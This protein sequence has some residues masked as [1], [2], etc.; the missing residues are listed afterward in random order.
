MHRRLIGTIA[1][2]AVGAGFG[3]VTLSANAQSAPSPLIGDR[4]LA[5]RPT[6]M[7]LGSVHLGNPARDMHD[8][9]V[10]DVLAPER[11]RQI[12]RVVDAIA[13]W[14]PT[15]IAV[16]W[17]HKNQAK[18]DKRYDD[19]LAGRYALTADETDQLALRLAKKLGLKHVD[20]VDWNEDAPGPDTDYDWEAGAKL[21]HEEARFAALRDPKIDREQTALVRDHTVAGF[22]RIENAPKS[23][24]NSNRVYYD[25][26][27]LGNSEVNPGANW[28]GY[29]HARNLKIL[30]N[31]IR[32]DARPSDRVLLVIG[33]GH[34][35]LLNEYAADSHAFRVVRP[36]AWLARAEDRPHKKP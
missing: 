20:A 9:K 24:A 13:Q 32:L 29:W 23:L 36:D 22:L 10:D 18:L 4:P 34:A 25:L 21:G 6:L 28:V 12:E 16:E 14:K 30:D 3:A 5:Q 1:A 27:L 7:V 17:G 31:L 35:Y 11:Q 19:Y 8:A 33:A 15:R 2:L 26:A